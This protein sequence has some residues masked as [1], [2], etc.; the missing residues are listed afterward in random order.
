[1]K[2]DT[3]AVPPTVTSKSST[4]ESPNT[5]TQ[6]T[7]AKAPTPWLQNKNKPQ[8]DLPEWAK[9]ASVNKAPND[10]SEN[11]VS[12]TV[13]TPIVQQ[14]SPQRSQGKQKEQEQQLGQQQHQ[15]SSPY[16]C[17]PKPQFQQPQQ[18]EQC[19]PARQHKQNTDPAISQRV[20]PQP[21]V[22]RIIPIR[23]SF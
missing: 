21:Q 3:K 14:T 7:L 19:Q 9:R 18:T 20:N 6:I 10:T 12:Q 8:E 15:P 23:V 11:I 4:P 16:Q 22:G 17:Q 1:M 13:F 5:P 2:I